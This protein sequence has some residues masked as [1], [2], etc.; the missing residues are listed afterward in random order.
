VRVRLGDIR[1]QIVDLED[2][3]IGE[4]QNLVEEIVG[5]GIWKGS[6]DDDDVTPLELFAVEPETTLFPR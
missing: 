1:E 2:D 6:L 3:G 5:V 4:G